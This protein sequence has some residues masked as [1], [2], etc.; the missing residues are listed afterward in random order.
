MSGRC[1]ITHD[2]ALWTMNPQ[3]FRDIPGLELA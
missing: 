1:A 2:A 3:D